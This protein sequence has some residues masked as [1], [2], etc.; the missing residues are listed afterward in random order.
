MKKFL[1]LVFAICI[2]SCLYT[3]IISEAED[4]K[5]YDFNFK[6]DTLYVDVRVANDANNVNLEIYSL[7][8]KNDARFIFKSVYDTVR[9]NYKDN[10][11]FNKALHYNKVL[12][13]S[14][15]VLNGKITSGK[16]IIHKG[17][18]FI[19][20]DTSNIKKNKISLELYDNCPWFCIIDGNKWR[21]LQSINF[22][23]DIE[24]WK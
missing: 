10:V 24:D 6:N 21:V 12:D 16:M 22:G 23:V 1:L 7:K 20:I 3:E 13:S 19:P 17:D 8:L 5:A 14:S 2:T 4:T 11:I 18:V 9:L 15:F